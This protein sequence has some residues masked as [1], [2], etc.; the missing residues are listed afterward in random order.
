M[1]GPTT[2]H[3]EHLVADLLQLE[4]PFDRAAVE[5]RELDRA[6][7]AEEVG[8]MQQVHV[9]G[10][11]LDP[12]AAVQE[13]AQLLD[14]F[15]DLDPACVLDRRAGRHLIGHRA[16]AADARRDV[17]RLGVGPPS[18]EALVEAGRLEDPELHVVDLP[19]DDAH[20]HAALALDATEG[21]G[22]E[23]AGSGLV[24]H[25]VLLSLSVTGTGRGWSRNGS[26]HA[27]NVWKTRYCS[28]S[29][30]PIEVSSGAS[31]SGRALSI[32]PKQ[33]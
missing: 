17:G 16:D 23:P 1:N 20:M 15:A 27:L 31:T 28:S 11:A 7:D 21:P 12:L 6:V 29:G 32:G 24:G 33:P 22:V 5:G 30:I 13:A 9:Q 3:L 10:V 25:D 26:D 14:R 2:D 4:T 19:V 18:Q 8:R